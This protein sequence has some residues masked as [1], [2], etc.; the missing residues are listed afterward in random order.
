MT[1]IGKA[2]ISL[3]VLA[4]IGAFVIYEAPRLVKA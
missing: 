2:V 4:A 1:T 3:A